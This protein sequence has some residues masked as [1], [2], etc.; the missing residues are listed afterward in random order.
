M[1][2]KG[3]T[4]VELL[5][6]ISILGVISLIIVPIID[7]VRDKANTTT[8]QIQEDLFELSGEDYF[9]S[10]R[11]LLP[12]VHSEENIV[13]LSTLIQKGYIEEI[14]DFKDEIC[15]PDL[16]YISV[17][18]VDIGK[19]NY[20]AH[21]ECDNYVTTGV[22]GEWSEWQV[23]T[24]TPEHTANYNTQIQNTDF[25]NYR[26]RTFIYEWTDTTDWAYGNPLQRIE[27][28]GDTRTVYRYKDVPAKWY[29]R[30]YN[31]TYYSTAP[32]G[33]PNKDE[34]D[35]TYTSW[36]IWGNSN[37]ANYSYREE[38]SDLGRTYAEK[39]VKDYTYNC[40]C[41]DGVPSY[42]GTA[43]GTSSS[44]CTTAHWSLCSPDSVYAS[45]YTTN[46]YKKYW[47]GD[48][49]SGPEMWYS[50]SG[51]AQHWPESSPPTPTSGY[52]RY[53][54]TY[55]GTATV[56]RYRDQKWKWYAQEYYQDGG[57]DGYS[58][59]EPSGYPYRDET[60]V[61][62]VSW[63]EEETGN[64]ITVEP[65]DFV[66][67]V[68]ESRTQTLNSSETF[69]EP[70]LENAVSSADF[71]TTVGSDIATVE[72]DPTFDVVPQAMYRYRIRQ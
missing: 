7:N 29:S 46:Y 55:L 18:N 38:Q 32:S 4:L 60:Q 13:Y 63:I 69:G 51:W 33:Y 3:F 35:T 5:A 37:P 68:I 12:K 48:N 22:W 40:Y 23:L 47:T 39:K 42:A 43:T 16:S 30:D 8:M 15:D 6:V 26:T 1:K 10:N 14:Y 34:S 9:L 31:A 24:E 20:T 70:I 44:V 21:L 36:S 54:Y 25:Y 52:T 61:Q 57:V 71:L 45:G 67:R 11:E 53:V 28:S 66:Y 64:P 50:N 2:I 72:A 41:N 19:Y 27:E 65:D 62:E 59:A 58:L 17:I 49:P 56:Y